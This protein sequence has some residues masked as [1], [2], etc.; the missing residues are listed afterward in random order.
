MTIRNSNALLHGKSK[1]CTSKVSRYFESTTVLSVY[2]GTLKVLWYFKFTA[3]K[4]HGTFNVPG[5]VPWYFQ[6]TVVKYHGTFKVPWYTK[7]TVVLSMHRGTLKV[8]WYVVPW[9]FKIYHGMQYGTNVPRYESTRVF[10]AR[11]M[12]RGS[13][14]GTFHGTFS[15]GILLVIK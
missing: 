7:S 15:Y 10:S 3:V 6:C 12:Y 5:K 13:F 14:H 8:P 9:Y 4:Y 2:R 1:K 11:K